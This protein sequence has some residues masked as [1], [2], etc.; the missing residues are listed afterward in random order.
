MSVGLCGRSTRVPLKPTDS[1]GDLHTKVAGAF[2]LS[3]PF[4]LVGSE[5]TPL[6]SNADA[7]RVFAGAASDGNS[8]HVTVAAGEEALLD[9]ERAHEESGAL[10]WVLLRQLITGL[11]T[12][13][14]EVSVAV[15]ESKHQAA[16][17]EEHLAREQM[18]REA[19]DTSLRVEAQNLLESARSEAQQSGQELRSTLTASLAQLQQRLDELA[20]RQGAALRGEVSV[21]RQEL[22]RE[23][24][25]RHRQGEAVTRQCSE[26]FQKLQQE[27][28]AREQGLASAQTV[29]GSLKSQL[30]AESR[31]RAVVVE[32]WSQEQAALAKELRAELE[33][34]LDQAG[35]Q[36]KGPVAQ[37][38]AAL[39]GVRRE[40]HSSLGEKVAHLEEMFQGLSERLA[41]VAQEAETRHAGGHAEVRSY[42][43]GRLSQVGNAEPRVREIVA[44]ENKLLLAQESA[45]RE[46]G[47]EKLR[48]EMEGLHLEERLQQE[49]A[50]RR[51]GLDRALAMAGS[52]LEAVRAEARS[53]QEG[54]ASRD[55]LD[56]ELK[57]K[58]QEGRVSLESLQEKV[59]TLSGSHVA[60]E[61]ELKTAV[62]SLRNEVRSDSEF[63]REEL[64]RSKEELRKSNEEV[65]GKASKQELQALQESLDDLRRCV[66]HNEIWGA[67][68]QQA[69]ECSSLGRAIEAVELRVTS[70]F[71]E[72]TAAKLLELQRNSEK[73]TADAMARMRAEISKEIGTADV[74]AAERSAALQDHCLSCETQARTAAADVKAALEANTEVAAALENSQKLLLEHINKQMADG[75]AKQDSSMRRVVALEQDM[76]KVRGHLPILF[77]S[78]SAFG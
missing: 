76:K 74:R 71:R 8:A 38:E 4:D 11:R 45:A 30:E 14:A 39:E 65:C 58:I 50:E 21:L 9:L 13:I 29:L 22:L 63:V 48:G 77:A 34:G 75:H 32:R 68:A 31:E 62:D 33:R 73:V 26:A 15:S 66:P 78:P 19:G 27:E 69:D 49:A 16:R 51:A 46:A 3:A 28:Q 2:G 20:E 70:E 23:C 44:Q 18:T 6:R 54:V 60:Q 7:A 72:H 59:L 37:L 5:G 57:R 35:A 1:L 24:D 56:E 47:L 55:V 52:A 12:Q 42:V 67:L 61:R 10:R 64:R 53:R 36:H 43:E 25:D 41:Q 40:A 17:L